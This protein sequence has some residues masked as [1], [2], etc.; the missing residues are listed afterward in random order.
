MY[1]QTKSDQ[2]E[3]DVAVKEVLKRIGNNVTTY[4]IL[5]E[6]PDAIRKK[7]CQ[8]SIGGKGGECLGGLAGTQFVQRSLQ[9]LHNQKKIHIYK[10]F[11]AHGAKF[12]MRD[13]PNG[14]IIASGANT[15]LYSLA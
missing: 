5:N 9:R 3:M 4:Q 15:A 6:L 7:T 13:A 10:G 11:N 2:I 1:Q 12:A 14:Y 8:N